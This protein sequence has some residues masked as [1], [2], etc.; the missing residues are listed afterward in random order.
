MGRVG[1]VGSIN[2]DLVTTIDRMPAAGETRAASGFATGRGGKG[3]NQATAAARAGAQV[4]FVGAIG[5]DDLGREAL[6]AFHADGIDTTHIIRAGAPTGTAT[7]IVEESG[8]N[9]ILIDAG[10]NAHLRPADI[11]R[12]AAALATCDLI[13]LQLEIPLE[14]VLHTIDVAAA[15]N[16]PVLLNPAPATADLPLDRF[17]TVRF[18]APNETELALLTG[19]STDTPQRTIDAG[20]GLLKD[21]F[22]SIIVTLGDAGALLIEPGTTTPIPPHPVTA[23]DTTGA[24]DAFLGSFAASWV[25]DRDALAALKYAARYAA[26]SVT[27]R[28]AQESFPRGGLGAAS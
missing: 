9:R 24:G 28:G 25:A 16:V 10:A 1:V 22:A 6:D 21:G 17:G 4:L 14:T 11:D 13:L 26:I 15:T 5:D 3:A 2:T 7:I 8:H 23:I 27:R 12:A 18:L 19:F 20:T